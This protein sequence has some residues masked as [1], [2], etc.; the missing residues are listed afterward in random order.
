VSTYVALVLE[1]Q[2]NHDEA[3]RARGE[4]QP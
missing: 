4:A 3:R 2:G 1:A